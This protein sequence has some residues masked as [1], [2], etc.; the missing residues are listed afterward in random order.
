MDKYDNF[1]Y[2]PKN[3]D[4]IR[5]GYNLYVKEDGKGYSTF[6][7]SKGNIRAHYHEKGCVWPIGVNPPPCNCDW[8]KLKRLYELEKEKH[9]G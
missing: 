3:T 2:R 1:D 9:N 6:F 4:L 7:D 8:C 5:I